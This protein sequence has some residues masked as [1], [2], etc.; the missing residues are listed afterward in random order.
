M[1][2]PT[3][4]HTEVVNLHI[5]ELSHEVLTKNLN[6]GEVLTR[7]FICRG[8]AY[9]DVMFSTIKSFQVTVE[10]HYPIRTPVA[11]SVKM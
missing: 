1:L 11:Y 9:L 6:Q 5:G 10:Y 4:L 2:L 8:T 7:R 3:A